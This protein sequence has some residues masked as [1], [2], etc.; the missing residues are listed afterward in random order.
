MDA[1]VDF[2]WRLY[3]AAVVMA[4]GAALLVWGIRLE[5]QGLRRPTRDPEHILSLVRGLRLSILG[6]SVDELGVACIWQVFWL[7][8][9]SLIFVGEEMLEISF[10]L[11]VLRRRQSKDLGHLPVSLLNSYK[12]RYKMQTTRKVAHVDSFEQTIYITHAPI[13]APSLIW[14]TPWQVLAR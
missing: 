4:V 13:L 8:V 10:V 1:L 6:L 9:L 3:P 5:V 12:P 7:F 2:S 14:R 11:L